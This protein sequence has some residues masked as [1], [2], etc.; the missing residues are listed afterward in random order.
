VADSSTIASALAPGV[1]LTSAVIYW[2]NLQSRM[3]SLAQRVRT[4]NK[5]LRADVK[6]STRALSI[7]LQVA[8]LTKRSRMLHVGVVLS[9]VALFGFLAS[10]A[11]LFIALARFHMGGTLATVLFTLGLVCFASSAVVT[12][13]EMLW[14]YRSLE[15]DVRS[16][17]PRDSEDTSGHGDARTLG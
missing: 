14:A 7:Q 4:L 3:D 5:E 12:L 11:I 8:M 13:W 10:S 2:A 15:E 17:L 6:G 1:A 9:V 16:S